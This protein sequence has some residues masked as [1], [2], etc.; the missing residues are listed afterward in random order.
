MKH[1][2]MIILRIDN[3]L[4]FPACQNYLKFVSEQRQKKIAKLHFEKDKL[5]SLFAG[6]LVRYQIIKKLHIP[7]HEI[8]FGYG[9]HGKPYLL[10]Q[11][12]YHF[13]LSHSEQCIAFADSS[14]PIGVDIEHLHQANMQIAES[15]F[16]CKEFNYIQNSCYPD[17]A[18][19]MVWTAK[20]AYLKMTGKGLSV[21]LNSFCTVS[22]I[23]DY[24]FFQTS[25]PDYT[26][27]ACIHH[28]VTEYACDFID[29]NLLMQFFNAIS[30]II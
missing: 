28:T 19:G 18:F 24:C 29:C 27:T 3:Q 1:N 12:K 20:E 30:T 6:L 22:G 11:E 13:S 23:P 26:A 4:S 10:Q 7:N 5:L 21:P 2:N 14:F 16:S 15:Y 17:K 9:S 8:I 25:F